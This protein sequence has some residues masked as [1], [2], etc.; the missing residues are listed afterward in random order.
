VYAHGG[1]TLTDLPVAL[2]FGARGVAFQ[3]GIRL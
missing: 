1:M 2:S 3:R